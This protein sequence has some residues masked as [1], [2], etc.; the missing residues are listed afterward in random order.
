MQL[1]IMRYK[2][3]EFEKNPYSVEI[4]KSKKISKRTVF[5]KGESVCETAQ[6]AEIITV[7]GRLY[8][9]DANE[10]AQSLKRLQRQS[11]SGMLLLPDGDCICAFLCSLQLKSE[12]REGYIEYSI[13]FTEDASKRG[14]PEINYG[15]TYA[16]DGENAF[17][18][19]KRCN[20]T[21]ESI[22][23]NNEIKTPF[24]IKA[25]ERLVI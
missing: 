14:T 9:E 23:K 16:L 19:A 8:G 7:K 10:R 15:F 12:A 1:I 2:D 20:T 3:F 13:E 25:G 17:D 22:M 11:G 24:D 18:I 4:S 5:G 6:N 21:V